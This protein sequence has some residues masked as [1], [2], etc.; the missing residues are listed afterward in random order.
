M[1]KKSLNYRGKSIVEQSEIPIS[2][3]IG[4]HYNFLL[5]TGRWLERSVNPAFAGMRKA[6]IDD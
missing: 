6:G 3:Q 4:I 2:G 5:D 1:L